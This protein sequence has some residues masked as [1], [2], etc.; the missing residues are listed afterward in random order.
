MLRLFFLLTAAGASAAPAPR[1]ARWP[2]FRG[3]PAQGIVAE[4]ALPTEWSDTK[5]V[6]WKQPLPGK[7]WSS[8]VTAAGRIYLTT[9][10]SPAMDG[11][12]GSLSL[13]ALCLDGQT[14][15]IKWAKEVFREDA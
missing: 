8:P 2:E 14:G 15:S 3:P 6:A 12:D 1:A 7:G 13:Q 9:A 11:K 4:G 5:N 10:S